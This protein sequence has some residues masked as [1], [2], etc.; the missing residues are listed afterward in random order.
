MLCYNLKHLLSF[1]YC[2]NKIFYNTGINK[3][4]SPL[5]TIR[6]IKQ[7]TTKTEKLNHSVWIDPYIS[8]LDWLLSV[9][10]KHIQKNPKLLQRIQ[11]LRF[12]K[13]SKHESKGKNLERIYGHLYPGPE[14]FNF[15]RFTSIVML[16]RDRH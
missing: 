16:P 15:G 7:D 1:D 4:I 12:Q 10:R 6:L 2:S 13:N 9:I 3:T 8:R 14:V 11:I 5:K